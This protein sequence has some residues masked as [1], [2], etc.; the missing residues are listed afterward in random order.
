[1]SINS[2]F[3][4][5]HLFEPKSL[6]NEQKV[7]C[8]QFMDL[9]ID[10]IRETKHKEKV[11]LKL[12]NVKIILRFWPKGASLGASMI[13]LKLDGLKF[14]Y[15]TDYS[16][17][18]ESHIKGVI[19]KLLQKHDFDFLIT[20][21]VDLNHNKVSLK[22]ALSQCLVG[23][24]KSLLLIDQI[25][26]LFEI[27]LVLNDWLAVEEHTSAEIVLPKIY[28]Y[29]LDVM[30]R[31]SEYMPPEISQNL[32]IGEDDLFT[33][34]Y[35]RYNDTRTKIPEKNLRILIATVTDFVSGR[36]FKD[37]DGFQDYDLLF[38]STATQINYRQLISK[39]E[40]SANENGSNSEF[41]IGMQN[42]MIG[43]IN[44]SDKN[45]LFDMKTETQNQTV[46]E[47]DITSNINSKNFDMTRLSIQNNTL[48]N[49]FT[50]N[51]EIAFRFKNHDVFFYFPKIE[52]S[53]SDYGNT[54]SELEL[55]V[56]EYMDPGH[57]FKAE[58]DLNAKNIQHDLAKTKEFF[59]EYLEFTQWPIVATSFSFKKEKVIPY[60]WMAT[61]K[62][63][64]I[65][66]SQLM[67]KNIL[68]IN[69]PEPFL[70]TFFRDYHESLTRNP[71][72]FI[73]DK[74]LS[75]PLQQQTLSVNFQTLELENVKFKSVTENLKYAKL[76]F[77]LH[78]SAG[79]KFELSVDQ[80]TEAKIFRIIKTCK[81]L[82]IKAFL[83]QH[84]FL[85]KLEVRRL[86]Y[87]HKV[88]IVNQNEQFVVEGIFCQEYFGI[89]E[90]L[91]QF[92][93]L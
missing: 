55:S 78:K 91:Y 76:T 67:V 31:L 49:D 75:F 38:D 86:N 63:Q 39:S 53:K 60:L 69:T 48:L 89:R 77:K 92:I 27:I 19:H 84:N 10:R 72:C 20:H 70:F 13:S 62:D 47:D 41:Q 82:K 12:K 11:E 37:S 61:T 34:K 93:N 24:S 83:A 23:T 71:A 40:I 29:Y 15:L 85:L 87:L 32:T 6:N 1:M 16:V 88:Y 28:T 90:L 73:L 9:L 42:K 56:M 57:D 14:C 80:V 33:L 35:T 58:K 66:L 64:V 50:A 2:L 44:L 54:L 25:P 3:F 52:K 79:S 8:L 74:Q 26:R 17:Q 65:L 68:F 46:V 30:K 43:A 81:L 18:D 59:D 5:L 21:L 4:S 22:N 45:D 36:V 7:E 51:D